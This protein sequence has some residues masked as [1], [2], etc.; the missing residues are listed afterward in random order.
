MVAMSPVSER[1]P[2]ILRMQS[3]S[4]RPMQAFARVLEIS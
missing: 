1:A 2:P 4:A 3:C